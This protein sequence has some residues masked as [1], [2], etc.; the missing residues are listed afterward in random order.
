MYKRQVPTSN[1][2][3]ADARGNI[4]YLWNGQVPKR[5]DDGT[6]HGLDVPGDTRK[7]V[8]TKLHKVDGLP[9]LLNP[10]GGY[11]QNANN[12]PWY[13]SLGDRLAPA[14]YPSYFEHGPL[15]PSAGFNPTT[16]RW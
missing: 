14:H 6:E 11:I 7:Y 12:P 9:R 13:T 8:W 15:V 1:F 4:L 5:L 3:Y 2:T 16:F 10:H